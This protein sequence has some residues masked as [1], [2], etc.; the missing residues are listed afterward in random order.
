VTG[1][2]NGQNASVTSGTLAFAMPAA[3]LSN[4][5]TY[6]ING[7]GLTANNRNYTFAQAAGN[8]TAFTINPAL[9]TYTATPATGTYGSAIPTLTGTVTGFVN[10][11][12]Q[13]SATTGTA[14]FTTPATASSN[15]GTYPINGSGLTANFGNY[16][17]T[18]AVGNATAFTINPALLTYTATSATRTY[19]SVNPAVTGSITGFVNGDTLSSA[20][21]GIAGFT[22]PATSSSNVGAYAINGSGLTANFGNY[23]FTQAAP[24]ATAFTVNPALLTY[25]A[26]PVTATYGSAIPVVSG[27]VVGFVNGQTQSSATSG[28]LAFMTPATTTSSATS[29]AIN[30]SGLTANFGNYTFTQAPTNAT[31]LTIAAAS[32]TNPVVLTI[33]VNNSTRLQNQSNPAF[34]AVYDGPP[35]TG[36]AISSI[37][38]GL[39]Y[40]TSA[41]TNSAAGTY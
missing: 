25:T 33:V 7:S 23:T 34:T 19:G 15:A 38:G 5:G 13:S 40:Q 21:T 18:Q 20:T 35:L 30:G 3:P 16:T 14:A 31:A 1:F 28:T 37:L 10:G 12:T 2:V 17:F 24:N 8:A 4:T 6:A 27:T 32:V 29:Y 39:T 26:T 22:S 41:V 36:V 11:Q 9:L